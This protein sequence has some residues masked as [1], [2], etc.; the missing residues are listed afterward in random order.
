MITVNKIRIVM[1][2]FIIWGT[3]SMGSSIIN[4]TAETVD[5]HHAAIEQAIGE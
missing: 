2:C 1:A 3:I 5:R 4:S